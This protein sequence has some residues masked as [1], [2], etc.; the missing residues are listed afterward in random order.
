MATCVLNTQ[1]KKQNIT[2]TFE[3]PGVTLCFLHRSDHCLE[4]CVFLFCYSFLICSSNIL[5]S[6]YF[7]YVASP[8]FYSLLFNLTLILRFFHVNA[9]SY[10]SHQF[11][12]LI[13]QSLFIHFLVSRPSGLFPVFCHCKQCSVNILLLPL[14]LHF[15]TSVS[16]MKFPTK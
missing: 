3:A 2:N 7:A 1:L 16:L 9:C 14:S 10:S 4:F 5:L 8:V 11:V 12:V 15:F 6:L 13:R